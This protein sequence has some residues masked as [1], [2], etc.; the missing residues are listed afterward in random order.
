MISIKKVNN[1]FKLLY[2]RECGK[3]TKR[4]DLFKIVCEEN[5]DITLSITICTDC[6]IKLHDLIEDTLSTDKAIYQPLIEFSN[7]E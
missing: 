6:L 2:C 3:M 4:D 7:L 1:G 5:N